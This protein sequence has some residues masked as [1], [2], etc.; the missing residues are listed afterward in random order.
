MKNILTTLEN[1]SSDC[2]NYFQQLLD[3]PIHPCVCCH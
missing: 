3:T 2:D 1:P